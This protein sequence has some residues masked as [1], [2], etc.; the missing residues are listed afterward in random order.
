MIYIKHQLF[1]EPLKIKINAITNIEF[2]SKDDFW[3]FLND[4][5]NASNKSQAENFDI[6][7]SK[8][9]K[10]IINS[11]TFIS[12]CLSYEYNFRK[13]INELHKK[14]AAEVIREDFADSILDVNKHIKAL[15]SKVQTLSF[16]ELEYSDDLE[17]IDLFKFVDLK[18]VDRQE[19]FLLKLQNILRVNLELLN[20]KVF[21]TNNL[22]AYL[23]ENE[24]DELMK[25]VKYKKI[26]LI[27][28]C[29]SNKITKK[30]ELTSIIYDDDKCTY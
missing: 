11:F 12:D 25:F 20:K 6:M 15:L 27:N 30:N 2:I 18:V 7:D 19:N 28:V 14:L 29:I 13:V 3:N 5:N 10:S 9:A 23:G 21:M 16:I 1:F 4:V 17:Y 24:T 26:T 22:F 8:L